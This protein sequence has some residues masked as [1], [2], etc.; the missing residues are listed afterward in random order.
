[1]MVNIAEKVPRDLKDCIS[2]PISLVGA[3]SEPWGRPMTNLCQ[4]LR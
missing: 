4:A 3:G 1:M 2:R